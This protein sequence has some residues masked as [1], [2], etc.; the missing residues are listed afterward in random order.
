VKFIEAM[1]PVG[2]TNIHEALK[3]AFFLVGTG[4]HD[5]NYKLGADTI[6]FL[7]DGQPTRGDVLDPNRILAEVKRWNLLRRVKVHTVGVGQGHDAS[8]MR[9]LADSSGGTYVHR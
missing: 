2:A 9:A 7:S 8:F 1:T 4:A 3:R 5:R 6:F